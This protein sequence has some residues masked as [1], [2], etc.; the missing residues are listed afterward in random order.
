MIQSSLDS[1]GVRET[2]RTIAKQA[3]YLDVTVHT[4]QE[5]A[6]AR[7]ASIEDALALLLS[8][9]AVAIR[10]SYRV[11]DDAWSDTLTRAADGFRLLRVRRPLAGWMLGGE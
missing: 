5:P 4:K 8:G 3:H 11:D 9:G 6:A 7:H 10:L 1:S 2:V